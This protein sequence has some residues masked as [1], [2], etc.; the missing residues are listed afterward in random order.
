MFAESKLRKS[1]WMLKI[2]SR[3]WAGRGKKTFKAADGKTRREGSIEDIN[4][5]GE[6]GRGRGS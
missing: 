6:R 3:K 1:G 2:V 5:I 4:V